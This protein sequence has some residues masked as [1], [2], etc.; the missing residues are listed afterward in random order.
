MNGSRLISMVVADR[1]AAALR[2]FGLFCFY[3]KKSRDFCKCGGFKTGNFIPDGKSLVSSSQ[4]YLACN[5]IVCSNSCLY[6]SQKRNDQYWCELRKK[7][8][9]VMTYMI[10]IGIW[11]SFCPIDRKP[12]EQLNWII[13]THPIVIEV[14]HYEF[15]LLGNGIDRFSLDFVTFHQLWIFLFLHK[16]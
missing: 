12:L 2:L 9:T 13:N 5:W 14:E 15:L 10:R 4:S 3:V 11:V 1:P 8:I 7:E 16:F 6:I